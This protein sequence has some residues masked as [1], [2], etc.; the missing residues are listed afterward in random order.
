[1]LHHRQMWAG[2]GVLVAVF[3]AEWFCWADG[4]P[5]G[6]ASTTG[7]IP[8]TGPASMTLEAGENL[9][10]KLVLVPEGSS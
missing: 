1:M 2:I 9:P 4:P 10:M 6:E 8:T 5:T 7:T 3:A